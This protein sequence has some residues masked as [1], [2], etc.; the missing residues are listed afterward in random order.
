MEQLFTQILTGNI[1][2][3]IIVLILWRSGVL[4]YLLNGKSTDNSSELLNTMERLEKHYNLETT[5]ALNSINLELHEISQKM[6]TISENIVYIKA[7]LN[8]K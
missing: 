5:S 6:S 4:K 2:T 1:G 3:I 8:N 7:K